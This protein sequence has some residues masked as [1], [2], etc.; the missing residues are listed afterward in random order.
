MA[1]L[2]NLGWWAGSGV[3]ECIAAQLL[4]LGWRRL[5]VGEGL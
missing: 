1:G 5:A 2:R 3:A 4:G